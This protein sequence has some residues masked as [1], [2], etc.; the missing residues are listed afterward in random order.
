M[1]ASIAASSR[2]GITD[3]ILQRIAAHPRPDDARPIANIILDRFRVPGE[4]GFDADEYFEHVSVSIIGNVDDALEAAG[5]RTVLTYDLPWKGGVSD[6]TY[7]L[8]PG[9]NEDT[10]E[11]VGMGS[12]Y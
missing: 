5:Y 6:L 1:E 12:P 8:T 10:E 7:I 9:G 3:E 4:G 2:P 11:E